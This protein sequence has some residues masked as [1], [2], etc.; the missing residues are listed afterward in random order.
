MKR[1]QLAKTLELVAINGPDA[2]YSGILTES[3]VEDI[4]INGGIITEE[5]LFKYQYLTHKTVRMQEVYLS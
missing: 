1:P 2:L 3:F 4:R 5:D